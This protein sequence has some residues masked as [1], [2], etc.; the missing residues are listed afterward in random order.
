MI[1]KRC[2]SDIFVRSS[3][4][5][6]VLYGETGVGVDNK[7]KKRILHLSLVDEVAADHVGSSR[8]KS[9]G[10]VLIHSCSEIVG[11]GGC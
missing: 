2:S 11:F 3:R 5:F 8:H 10:E 4:K 7:I 1:G 6:S 9:M